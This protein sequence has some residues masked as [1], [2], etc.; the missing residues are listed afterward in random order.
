MFN[1]I[2]ASDE[3]NGIGK[4]N[5]IPWNIPQDI[6]LFKSLTSSICGINK[7]IIMGYNTMKS[8]KNGY[9]KN[10]IN[11]VITSKIIQK[12]NDNNNIY[13]VSNLNEALNTSYSLV[14]KDASRIWVIGGSILYNKAINHPDLNLIYHSR[15]KGNYECDVKFVLPECKIISVDR[16]NDFTLNILSPIYN[17]EVLYLRLLNDVLINGDERQTRNGITY[18]LFGKELVFNVSEYFPLLTTKKMFMKGIIEEL[19]FFIRGDTDTNNLMEK[20]INI[21]KGNTTKEFLNKLGLNYKEG[22]MGPMYGYQWR[23][24]G[25]EYTHD[26]HVNYHLSECKGDYVDQFKLL[27]NTL[28]NDSNS[29]RLLMT[30]FNPLMVNE[31]VLY[32]CH[33]LILQFYVNDNKLSVKMYQRSADLFLGLP[34]NIASTSLLL[35]IVAKLV[36][37]TPDMVHITLGDCHIYESHINAVKEQLNRTPNCLPK[38]IIPEFKTIEEVEASSYNDYTLIDYIYYPP[39]KAEMIA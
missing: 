6:E 35:Y 3:N 28:K 12:N 26:T 20:G 38:L 25:K 4:N 21:W 34:F 24:F 33:S 37:M 13:Y 9:L 29:R 15:I 14:G 30:D 31:G 18:S 10:R 7:V 16:M 8:L 1:I 19:L 36:N 39:I 5:S 2:L 11:I 23:F 17:V 22:M 32:P 27:I